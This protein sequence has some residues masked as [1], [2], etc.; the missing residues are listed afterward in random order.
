MLKKHLPTSFCHA[1]KFSR[2]FVGALLITAVTSCACT[3]SRKPHARNENNNKNNEI[4]DAGVIHARQVKKAEAVVHGIKSNVKGTV[5]FTKVPGGVKIVAD[6]DGL[7]PGKHGFHIHEHG[8]CSGED[9][10]AAG[11]HFNP[12]NHKHGGP[13]SEE[14]HVGDFGNLEADAKGHA[15]YERVDRLIELEGDNSII[16]RSI[17]IHADEDDLVSQPSGNSGARIG[18]GVIEF[19]SE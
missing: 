15:H 9:G 2:F 1:L 5:T 6:I 17:M 18:C 13:D 19:K 11:A 8:D 10:M 12:T 16:G 3:D 14:R 7:T 4:A